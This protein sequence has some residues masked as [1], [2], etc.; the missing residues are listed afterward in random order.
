MISIIIPCKDRPE[1][2]KRLLDELCKQKLEYPDT[3]IIVVENGCEADMSF[4]DDYDVIHTYSKKGVSHA[5]NKGLEISTGKYICWI[6]NDD[7]I[8]GDYLHTIYQAILHK[9]YDWV[10]WKWAVDGIDCQVN[11]DI[12]NP[13]KSQWALW[14]YCIKKELYTKKFDVNKKAGEDFLIFEILKG[15]GFLIDKVLYHFT[16]EGNEDSLSHLF[17]KGLL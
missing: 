3:E 9:D 6:D 1:S 16:W 11:I 5:R 4:I 8:A 7:M 12:S 10:V 17:N 2:T 13:L 14:C 15:N